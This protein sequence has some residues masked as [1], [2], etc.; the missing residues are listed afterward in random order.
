M[1]WPFKR[2]PKISFEE[3]ASTQPAAP[4]G[5]QNDHYFWEEIEG[6]PCPRCA[7]MEKSKLEV[8]NE[9][10]LAEKIAAALYRRMK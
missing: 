3:W 1:K 8:E 2:K 4:C 10:R 5:Y 7:A 9:N 6:W